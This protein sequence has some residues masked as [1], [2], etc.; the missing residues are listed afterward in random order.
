MFLSSYRQKKI[1]EYFRGKVVVITGASSG[2]G[3]ALA[4]A[5]GKLGAKILLTAR[6][7]E[8][9]IRVAHL[10]NTGDVGQAVVCK[11]D[12]TDENEVLNMFNEVKKNF[13][14]LD[15][16]ICNAGII[17]YARI[18]DLDLAVDRKIMNTNYHGATLCIREAV[19]IMLGQGY[20][21]IFI[22]NSVA[23]FVSPPYSSSYNASKYAL[24]AFVD[25][26][27]AELVN[28]NIFFTSFHP[29]DFDSTE[30]DKGKNVPNWSFNKYRWSKLSDIVQAAMY[31]IQKR[32]GIYVFPRI[33][34]YLYR[35]LQGV[36]PGLIIWVCS[37]SIKKDK[38]T[39]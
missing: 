8:K 15:I 6:R 13:G 32:K 5:L 4:L 38:K 29:G 31:A 11:C 14:K 30:L 35:F 10:I 21:H 16:F 17:D 37:M 7:E 2:F 36:W 19:K 12:V 28:K 18:Q 39:P 24:K 27:K 23:G 1:E 25:S 33:Y 20:G 26:A 3:E 22:N 34:F 9:L